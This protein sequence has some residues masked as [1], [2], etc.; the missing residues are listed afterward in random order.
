M[1]NSIFKYKMICL[2]LLTAVGLA[3]CSSSSDA[4]LSSGVPG[5]QTGTNPIPL[6]D[7][8]AQQTYMGFSGGL[9]PDASSTPP[10]VHDEEGLARARAIEPL[11]TQGHPDA[12]GHYV[13]MSIGFSNATQE[14][15]S[16]SSQLVTCNSWTF[17]GRA[18]SDSEVNHNKLVIVDGAK[19]GE[20][21]TKW[22]SSGASD[23]VRIRDDHLTP[24]GLTEKQ[25]VAVWIKVNNPTPTISLPSDRAEAFQLKRQYGSVVRALKSRYINLKMVF[26]SSRI[27]AGYARVDLHPEPYAYET[28]FGVKWVIEAQIRQM[29]GE[30]T[31]TDAGNLDYDNVAPWMAWGP[32]LW[33]NGTTARSDGLTW[34]PND[35]E[36]DGTHPAQSAETKVGD[37]LLTFFKT[38]PYTRCWF[39]TGGICG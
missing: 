39:V 22:L 14:W 35:Y 4:P 20:A 8:S 15:C 10:P 3:G 34:E 23:Y 33:A 5:D 18:A 24:L 6:I 26:F 37:L 27:Y 29:N 16:Q 17:M 2:L 7:M 1:E 13:L 38:S 32:Y 9:Y 31:D 12:T 30:G 21:I 36:S 19:G 11:D 25:V 28:G